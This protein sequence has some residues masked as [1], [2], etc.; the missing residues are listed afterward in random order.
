MKK[1]HIALYTQN[2][3]S[4]YQFWM[5]S[6]HPQPSWFQDHLSQFGWSQSTSVILHEWKSTSFAPTRMLEQTH[7]K[8]DQTPGLLANKINL[9]KNLFFIQIN[10]AC[11]DKKSMLWGVF[12]GEVN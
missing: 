6:P 2:T 10:P 5:L 3:I 8:Q 1:K 7:E 4:K 12:T 11:V 9:N